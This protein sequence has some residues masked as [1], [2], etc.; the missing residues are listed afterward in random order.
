VHQLDEGSAQAN[1]PTTGHRA[2]HSSTCVDRP[3]I[4]VLEDLSTGRTLNSR[5]VEL[6][7]G[8]GKLARVIPDLDSLLRVADDAPSYELDEIADV[9]AEACVMRAAAASVVRSPGPRPRHPGHLVGSS[10]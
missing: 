7:F 2:R 3:G 6:I 9:L 4:V 10:R 8:T 1:A 5:L